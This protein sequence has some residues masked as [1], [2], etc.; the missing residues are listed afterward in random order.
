MT[1][2]LLKNKKYI[3]YL[4][5]AAVVLSSVSLPLLSQADEKVT[6]QDV[7]EQTGISFN[8]I[9]WIAGKIFLFGSAVISALLSSFFG[10]F[11][12]IEA[13]IIDYILSPNYFPLTTAPIV[14]TGWKISRD[15][16]NMFFILILLI[17]AFATVLKIKVYAIQ[18]LLWKVIVV[19]LLI[20]FSLV[21]AGFIIDFTQILTVFFVKQM[22]GGGV[23]SVTVKLINGMNVMN[24]Y[25]PVG[26]EGKLKG[27]TEFGSDT[28]MAILGLILT[29]VGLIV[30]VFVFGATA[31]FL[32]V[33]IIK[34][35]YLLILAPL[36][37]LLWILPATS[38]YFGSWWRD[39]IKWTF[40]APVYAFF[41]YLTLTI[42]DAGGKLDIGKLFSSDIGGLSTPSKGLTTAFMPL[43]IFQWILLIAMMIYALIYA[44]NAGIKI[45]GAAQGV[46][47]GWGTATQN[48]AG[49]TLRR[50]ALAVGAKEAAPGVEARPGLLVRG[51]QKLAAVPGGRL[52]AGQ[53]FKMTGAE[54]GTIEAAQKQF[55]PWTP[56][57]IKVYL[58]QPS[59]RVTNRFLQNQQIGAALALKE[60]GKLGELDPDEA[61]TEARVR[62]LVSLASRYSPKDVDKLLEVAPY[63]A[64]EFNKKIKDI[65]AKVE[66]ANQ[67]TLTSMGK[68]EVVLNLNP[69]QLKDIV[70]K[71]DDVKVQL[72]KDTVNNE[73]T[74]L[75]VTTK[76]E[77]NKILKITNN[78]QR[79][80][81]L[82]T[83]LGDEL[84]NRI[85]ARMSAD[86]ARSE[87]QRLEKLIRSKA[88][89]SSPAWEI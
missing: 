63:L 58:R 79:N 15:L 78:K 44:Q 38:S 80:L 34:I 75:A 21:I 77:I 65:V 28:I 70:Q 33:R 69:S 19:A 52:L 41:L 48:W 29:L 89:T 57:A 55:A 84:N 45:A 50:G 3:V 5:V 46:L 62:E 23:A 10:I 27:L 25:N 39:F 40:F 12:S 31:I 30:T 32:I 56:E 86:Q 54:A 82:S 83:F 76:A 81:R 67:M 26:E 71:A 24:F 73:F 43:A 59:G 87:V 47:K 11:L 68:S 14:Q 74:G 8:P 4:L 72:L 16:A 37:W 6:A 1:K 17:I 66:K 51:A 60:K 13:K 42:F 9:S 22:V 2:T 20:N 49:R 18:Q 7:G 88:T 61:K 35:W 53:I 85:T 64:T 36:A